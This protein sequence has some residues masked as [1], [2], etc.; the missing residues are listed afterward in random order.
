VCCDNIKHACLQGF[1]IVIDEEVT[2]HRG[3]KHWRHLWDGGGSI[4][5][6]HA[7]VRTGNLVMIGVALRKPGMAYE[8]LRKPGMADEL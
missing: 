8:L 6:R 2:P 4:M 5:G 7:L 1:R 3:L